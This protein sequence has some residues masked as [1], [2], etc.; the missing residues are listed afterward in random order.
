MI[1]WLSL[2]LFTYIT[3]PT[4]AVFAQSDLIE[5]QPWFFYADAPAAA[6]FE[7]GVSYPDNPGGFTTGYRVS[8]TAAVPSAPWS[9]AMI[10]TIPSALS[11]G[12]SLQLRFWARSAS[13]TPIGIIAQRNG[14][15]YDSTLASD[16]TLTPDWH[17]YSYDITSIQVPPAGWMLSFRMALAT[18][19]VEIAGIRLLETTYTPPPPGTD[20]LTGSTWTFYGNAPAVGQMDAATFAEGPP[21]FTS[22]QRIIMSVSGP[23][24]WS[25]AMTTPIPARLAE[26]QV[27]RLHYWA[28][29]ETNSSAYV[30]AEREGGDFAKAL[31]VTQVFKPQWKEYA[32]T[33][34]ARSAAPGSWAVRFQTGR[35]TGTIELAGIRLEAWGNNPNPMPPSINFDPYG[36]Q[37]TDNT[38]RIRAKANI[39]TF[40]KSA[41]AVRVMDQTGRAVNNANITIEQK[42]HAFR[43]GTA[44]D[45]AFVL[46]TSEDAQRYRQ[47]V[48][49]LFNYAV[50]E[51]AL[52]WDFM[53][54]DPRSGP[55]VVQWC[56]DN[57]IPIRGHNV[58]WPY[59]WFLPLDVQPLS[60]QAYRDAIERRTRDVVGAMKGKVTEWDVVNEAVDANAIE[61]GGRDLLWKTYLWA[62]EADP[63]V[64]LVYNDY[65][66]ADNRGGLNTGHFNAVKAVVEELKN[67]GAPLTAVG[68]QAHMNIPL[69]PINK[70]VELWNELIAVTDLPLTV[71]EFDVNLGGIRDEA[72]QAQ[73]TEDFMTAAF[74]NPKVRDFLFWGFWDG[75]HWLADRGA[76]MYRKD[77]SRRPVLDTYERLVFKDWWTRV[78][79]KT[80]G[81]VFLTRAFYGTHTVTVEKDGQ[82]AEIS[83]DLVPGSGLLQT[84]EVRLP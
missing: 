4:P 84:V 66:I 57:G 80:W 17:E 40:R 67:H 30:I 19:T 14:P 53:S 78:T 76:G 34:I 5:D 10:L 11:E 25:A 15:P 59:S 20:L 65:S 64:G 62:R 36:G 16:V 1:R 49:R 82:R 50:P 44:L 48:K 72:A 9:S 2:L 21:G 26:G 68:D 63:T 56:L 23:E 55:A 3:L 41:L 8:I 71:T 37:K 35:T 81:G 22:G 39:E 69:T 6:T 38:W 83:V 60:G 27:L 13:Y 73:Y 31:T 70:V 46:G 47:E 42:K 28:R 58:W 43:W 45:H 74:G 75:A 12:Q 77:W 18:G 61:Q 32:Y 29:S 79:G 54:R 24:L 7:Q 52:K 33:F 51:N